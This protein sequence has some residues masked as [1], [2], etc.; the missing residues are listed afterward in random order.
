LTWLFKKSPDPVSTATAHDSAGL[1]TGDTDE[2][3]LAHRASVA[4]FGGTI[5]GIPGMPGSVEHRARL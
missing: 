1:K 5:T 3:S 2:E 4:K